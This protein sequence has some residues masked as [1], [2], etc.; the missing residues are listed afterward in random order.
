MPTV[1]VIM[2]CHNGAQYLAEAIDSVYEQTFQDF[3]II[4]Y[5][6][7]STDNS[8]EI[9]AGYDER[10]I[11]VRNEGTIK[12][13]GA[14]RKEAVTRATGEWIAF[15]DTDDVW[16]PKKLVTQL[17]QLNR[18]DYVMAY[19]GLENMDSEGKYLGNDIPVH[20]SG[21][22]FKDLLRQFEANLP[23]T[24]VKRSFLDTTGITFD[25]SMQASEDYNLFMQ[26]ASV[27][28]VLVIKEVLAKYRV[29]GGSLTF[30]KMHRWSYERKQ[31]LDLILTKSA[32]V[33]KNYK[34]EMD[35]AYAR[36]DYYEACA[37]MGDGAY[38]RG[39][40][41]MR[42]ASRSRGGIYTLLYLLTFSPRFWGFIHHPTAK[43]RIKNFLSPIFR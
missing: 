4:F 35:E 13:L 25:E 29:H 15:L 26:I 10:M 20:S 38:S 33:A 41:A 22:L 17:D 32:G 16:L 9:A 43:A 12:T 27:G 39:R 36:A 37:S 24:V 2:N 34:G 18:S 42:N 31:T 30:Q 28:K 23:T 1:S 19:G 7:A 6:N 14:A 11:V 8:L 21:F 5:D 40:A 3:E